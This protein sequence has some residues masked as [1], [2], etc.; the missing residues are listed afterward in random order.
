MTEQTNSNYADIVSEVMTIEDLTWGDPKRDFVV[1]FRGKLT[2][3]RKDARNRLSQAFKLNKLSPI[4][5]AEDGRDVVMLI[6]DPISSIV[7]QVF[8]I[9]DTQWG[10]SHQIYLVRFLGHL[11]R[12]SIEAYDL[13]EKECLPRNLT[14]LFREE[15]GQHAIILLKGVNR[16]QP[17]NPF[18]NL[19]LF[20]LTLVS[21]TL[22]GAMNVYTGAATTLSEYFQDLFTNLGSGLPFAI[23][24]MAILLAHEFGHYIA[25]RIHKTPVTLPYFLPLPVQPFGT[26]GAFI[27]LRGAPKNKRILHDIGIAGPLAGLFVAIPVLILGLSLSELNT[28]PL[29]LPEGQLLME[30]NSILYLLAKFAVFG[31]WLPAPLDF[32]GMSPALYWLRYFFTGAPFPLGGLDVTIHPV[33]LAGWGGLLI[34][35]LNLIPAGQLDG[36]HIIYV[37]LGRRARRL[38]PVIL[39]LMVILGFSWQGWWLF[40]ILISLMGR[41]FAEPLDQI[42]SLDS[43]RRWIAISGMVIFFLVFTPVPLMLIGG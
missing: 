27:Q 15:E 13:L 5:R 31:Q 7:S 10:E 23:S 34:T 1:R 30:G 25:G 43:R 4:V 8:D 28:L 39:T 22:V 32:G 3:D 19:V 14:P 16:P 36:G 26:L 2:T 40:A 6:S 17:A 41:T 20:L 18:V 38:M 42:T 12:D 33:A 9:K 11:T 29:S 24:L 35:A 37:L 21:I